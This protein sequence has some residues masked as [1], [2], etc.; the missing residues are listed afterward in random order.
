MRG[1]PGERRFRWDAAKTQVAVEEVRK[2]RTIDEAV[3][4][5]RAA[6]AWPTMTYNAIREAVKR[7]GGVAEF[8]SLLLPPEVSAEPPPA[9]PPVLIQD[10]EIPVYVVTEEPPAEA[11]ATIPPPPRSSAAVTDPVEELVDLVNKRPV[12]FEELCDVL[13]LSPRKVREL[14]DEARAR[15]FRVEFAGDHVGLRPTSSPVEERDVPIARAGDTHSIALVGDIHFGSK[16]HLGPQ[17]RDY[18]DIAYDRGVRNFLHVGDLLDG[19]YRHSVWE[20]SHRGLEDQVAYAIDNLPKYPGARWDFILGNHDETLGEAGLEVGVYVERAFRAAGRNDLYYQGSRAAYVRLRAPGEHRGLL[21][22]LWH[23]R[24]K[25]NAYAKSYRLQKKVEKYAPGQKPDVVA[26]GHWHQCFYMP[27]RGVHALST[28]C[29]QGGQSS[30][31]K[32]LGGAP[33]IGSWI[34]EYSLTPEGTV[35]TFKPEWIAY[36]ETETVREVGLG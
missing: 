4:R 1:N 28:G 8:V 19:N 25:A 33:D 13:E 20:Q 12:E 34:V 17:F 30:F 24:D 32:S 16:H 7:Y 18:C 29:W 3:A 6:L 14:V 9:V 11:P 5:V 27:I 22:E 23:P 2:S 21:V 31:G 10:P 35:R 15:G 36:Y 26:A